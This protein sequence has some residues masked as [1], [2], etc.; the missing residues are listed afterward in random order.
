M[1]STVFTAIY[2]CFSR[3]IKY[4][5]KQYKT[6]TCLHWCRVLLNPEDLNHK[7]IKE[8]DGSFLS[9]LAVFSKICFLALKKPLK[10]PQ[11][12]NHLMNVQ[13]LP[14]IKPLKLP[15]S[16]KFP[17]FSLFVKFSLVYYICM[18]KKQKRKKKGNN[19]LL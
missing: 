11:V 2:T 18:R 5:G 9:V 7:S 1:Y 13:K 4:K 6:F 17:M 19:V 14:T 10:Q 16:W 12:V 8:T 15:I 3:S